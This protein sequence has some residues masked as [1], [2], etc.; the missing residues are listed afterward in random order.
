M[1]RN[2][3][4]LVLAGGLLVMAESEAFGRGRV[5]GI[6]PARAGSASVRHSA[7]VGSFGAGTSSSARRTVVGPA[8]GVRSAG[9]ASGS[10]TTARGTNVSYG[11]AG[12]SVSGPLGGTAGRGVGGVQVTTPGGQTAT[13]VGR[14]GGAVGPGGVAVGGRSSAA[15]TTGPRGTAA[16]VS[17]GRTAIG[18]AG[19]VHTGYRGGAAVGP[20]GVAAGGSRVGVATGR[21]GTYHVSS[22]ALRTRGGYVRSGFRYYNAFSPTWYTRYPGAW[23]AAGWTAGR[24]WIVATWPTMV[25]YCGFPQQPIYIDYGTTVVYEGDTVYIDGEKAASAEQYAQQATQIA[26]AGRAAKPPEKEDFQPLGV[27]ALVRGE[28]ETSDKIFQLAVNKEGVIRGNYYDAI[29]DNTLPVY[30]SVDKKTQ[31]AAWSIGDKKDVVFEAGIANLTQEETPALVHYGKDNTQ[32][33]TL[34]RVEKPPEEKKD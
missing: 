1:T 27:F 11:G 28:E 18:P 14:A 3:L 26:D 30:G 10:Y 33:F 9:A 7:S 31:R 17:G 32:Q 6:A 21:Y 8:G 4:A 12:R 25:A 2:S 23:F 15:A 16:T 34:V 19:A 29:A 20:L 24:V 5:G 22:S 13:K